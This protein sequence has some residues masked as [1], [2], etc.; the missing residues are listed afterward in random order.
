AES[1][2][3]LWLI[4]HH[5]PWQRYHVSHTNICAQHRFNDDL[6]QTDPSRLSDQIGKC[7]G[8]RARGWLIDIKDVQLSLV[9]RDPNTRIVP[10]ND[11]LGERVHGGRKLGQATVMT[12]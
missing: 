1:C 6:A 5:C 2:Q 9:Q 11:G 8:N 10:S 3:R 4:L 12:T 7:Q